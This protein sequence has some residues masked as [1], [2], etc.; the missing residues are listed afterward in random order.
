M[1]TFNIKNLYCHQ[2]TSQFVAKELALTALDPFT[3]PGLSAAVWAAFERDQ[4]GKRYVS[5]LP[6]GG[7]NP[8]LG[9]Q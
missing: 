4:Q 7:Y 2:A 8:S 1:S 3:K 9:I 5:P 6:E